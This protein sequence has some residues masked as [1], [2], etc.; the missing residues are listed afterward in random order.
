MFSETSVS[1]SV[2]G[3]DGFP[4]MHYRSHDW[5]VCLQGGLHPGKGGLHPRGRGSASRGEGSASGRGVGQTSPPSEIHGILRNTVNKRA[6]RILL[7][8]ILVL[9]IITTLV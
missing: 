2:Q 3:G 7:E 4:S 8:C 6:I 9:Y 1:H 5:G